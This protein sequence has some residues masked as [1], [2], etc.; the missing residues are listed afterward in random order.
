MYVPCPEEGGRFLMAA[1]RDLKEARL[2]LRVSAR[3]KAD[4]EEAAR[5]RAESVSSFVKGAANAEAQRVLSE[6][7]LFA[8][9]AERWELFNQALD[10]P[11]VDK[12]RLRALLELP[13]IFET[14][15]GSEEV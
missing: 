14:A 12:P 3:E 5:S 4:L 7:T 1:A 9:D 15:L 2:N 8:I 10:R 6:R 13:S 11:V